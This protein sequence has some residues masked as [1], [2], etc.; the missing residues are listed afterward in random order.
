MSSIIYNSFK[1]G[2]M[3]GTFNL[4]SGG[5]VLKVA[6]LIGYTANAAHTQFSDV[7]STEVSGTAYT[8][9]GKIIT[10]VVDGT[11]S[12]AKIDTKGD[13]TWAN[14]TITATGA[15]I[16]DTTAAGSP[17]ICYIDFGGSQSTASGSFTL[18]WTGSSNVIVSIA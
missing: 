13:V 10:T 1:S 9:G 12:T 2:L 17:L 3:N 8:S 7:S 18:S 16:Y 14:S 6:L 15:V 11:T 4:G 5:D